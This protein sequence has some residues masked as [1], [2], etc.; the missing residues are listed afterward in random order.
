MSLLLI[1]L[2][3]ISASLSLAVIQFWLVL[4]FFYFLGGYAGGFRISEVL[5]IRV[6]D[7]SIFDFT[8]V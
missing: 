6:R 5:S 7:I 2:S 4:L 3:L 8:K 1:T